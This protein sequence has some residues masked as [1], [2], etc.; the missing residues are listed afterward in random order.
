MTLE[1]M[2]FTHVSQP[3]EYRLRLRPTGSESEVV[4]SGGLLGAIEISSVLPEPREQRAR[5]DGALA[6]IFQNPTGATELGVTIHAAAT[7]PGK[8]TGRLEYAGDAI[9]LWQF[10]YP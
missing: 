5:A 6:L 9:D 3:M 2:R 4:I 1:Y 7:S 10:A 8:H